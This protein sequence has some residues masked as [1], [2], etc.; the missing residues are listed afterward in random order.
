MAVANGKYKAKIAGFSVTE[1]NAGDPQIAVA[2]EFPY[3]QGT[4]QL[5]WYGSLKQGKAREITIDAL[6]VMGLKGNDLSKLCDGPAGG[7]LDVSKELLITVENEPRRDDPTK[8]DAR[9]RWI[10]EVG[11]A[12]FKGMLDKAEA[13]KRLGGLNIAADIIERRQKTGYRDDRAAA[14]A[15]GVGGPPVAQTPGLD[16]VP[17]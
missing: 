1:T 6:L 10:N 3:E 4:Q 17:F 13:I 7:A 8:I 5:T 2:L 16:E 11:G 12:R 9:V 15:G 14:P